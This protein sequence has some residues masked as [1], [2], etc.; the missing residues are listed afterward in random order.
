MTWSLVPSPFKHITCPFYLKHF[1]ATTSR[2]RALPGAF[3][4]TCYLHTCYLH[5]T[6]VLRVKHLWY[7]SFLPFSMYIRPIANIYIYIHHLYI[8]TSHNYRMQHACLY[9]YMYNLYI[10]I[11]FALYKIYIH[12]HRLC[13]TPIPYL[14][15]TKSHNYHHTPTTG[16]DHRVVGG[17]GLTGAGSYI[18]AV[19]N[20]RPVW[21]RQPNMALCQNSEPQ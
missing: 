5:T 3:E 21:L 6:Y 4:A 13:V 20:V 7:K 9:I 8:L 12:L 2:S 11:Y 19:H 14:L 15:T 18:H 16:Q 17:G 10:Y 1:R